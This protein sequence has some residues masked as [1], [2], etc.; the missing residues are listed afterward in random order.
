VPSLN[1]YLHVMA[2]QW[3]KHNGVDDAKVNFVEVGFQQMADVLKGGSVDAVDAI[4]PYYDRVAAV[5]HAIGNPDETAPPG[6]LTSVYTATR[7]WTA[8][9]PGV[10]AAFRQSLEEAQAFIAANEAAARESL[11]RWTRQP[12]SVV[13]TTPMPNLAVTIRPSQIEFFIALAREQ[14]LITRDM[15]AA[16]LI[17][18]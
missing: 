10:V 1:T 11:G 15:D 12:A 8:A 18:P 3:L 16:P 9:N 7:A 5:G 14:G 2:R 17:A 4:D 13:A 6:T